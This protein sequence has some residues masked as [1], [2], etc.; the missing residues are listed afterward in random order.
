MF[1]QKDW[2]RYLLRCGVLKF[3]NFTL[4]DGS[5][6]PF[7]LDFGAVCTGPDLRE[8]GIFFCQ[9]IEENLGFEGVDFLY[10]PPYK[11]TVMAAATAMGLT[12]Q[13]MPC[14]FTRKETKGH[15]EG[16]M[17]FGFQPKP[18]DNYLLLDDVMSS[19]ATKI[20]ALT[21]LKEQRCKAV[22]VGVDRQ[23]KV[24]GRTAAERFTEETGIPVLS[25]VTLSELKELTKDMISSEEHR[26]L[27]KY[28][29][30]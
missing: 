22:V 2:V 28:C 9:R 24:D 10:G 29:E 15:G 16:G 17:S 7:F 26:A 13:H 1:S 4:K 3:G 23:H 21:T 20:A 6:S 11:A 18:G 25:L 27:A 19:G 8:L 30:A 14:L 12:T 5:H